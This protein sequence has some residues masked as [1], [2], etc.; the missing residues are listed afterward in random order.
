MPQIFDNNHDYPEQ[1]LLTALQESLQH[2]QTMRADFCVGYFNLRGWGALA[3]YVETWSGADDNCCRVLIGMQA[4]PEAEFRDA[5]RQLKQQKRI[6]LETAKKLE[7]QLALEFREQLTVGLPTAHDERVL[8]QL[9]QQL[10]TRKL[11]VKLYTRQRLHAKL[12][13]C[14]QTDKRV[15]IVGYLG[16]S[17]LTLSGLSAQGELNIDVVEKDATTKL[18]E[19]FE[20]RWADRFSMDISEELIRV[21]EDSWA[22]EKLVSPY[23]IYIKM[24]Y[25]LSRE[26][27]S[28]LSEFAIP[29]VFGDRLF[30]YQTAAVKVAAHHLNKRGGVLIGDVVGL[31]K[32]LM[33]AALIKI[34]EEDYGY[35]TLII[36]PKNLESMWCEEYVERYGLRAK[37]LSITMVKREL[38]DLRRFRMVVLD[39]SHNLRNRD[40][41]IYRTIRDYIEKNECKCILLSATPYNKTYL[42]L[43]NQLRLFI[44]DNKSLSIRP[45]RFIREIGE[46]DFRSKYQADPRSLAAFEH[47]PHPE[48]W[49]DLMRLFMVRRT[50]SFIQQYYASLDEARQRYYLTFEDG[51]H[52]YFPQRL[53]KTVKFDIHRQYAQLYDDDV[54]STING[55]HLPRYG[56]G[57]YVQAKLAETGNEA[58]KGILKDL[59]K[60]GKRLM[61][62]C[63][64]NLFKRLES[65]GQIFLQSLERHIL[66]NYVYLYALQH[67]LELPIGTQDISW[68][69]SRQVDADSD[70]LMSE[71]LFNSENDSEDNEDVTEERD[72]WRLDQLQ[73]QAQRL[74]EQYQQK[75]RRR[76]KWVSSRFF[77]TSLAK[78][79]QDDAN[80][81]L[82]LL[83]QCGAWNPVLDDKLNAL[84]HL[85]TITHPDEKIIIF[86]Q[87]A[88]TVR[89]LEQQLQARGMKA[90]A[91]VTG[92]SDNPTLLAQR[93]SP[94]S[95]KKEIAS[96]DELRVLIATDVLSE[97]QNLQDAHIVVNFDIAWAIIR[98]IQRAGRVDRIGQKA[99]TIYCYTFLPAEGVERVIRLR[100]RVRQ[101]LSEN[102]EVV[103]TDEAFFEDDRNEQSVLDLYNERAGILDAEDDVDVDL[104]SYAYQ[105]WQSAIERDNA[106]ENRIKSLPDVTHASKA[107]IP[108]LNGQAG[109]LVYLRASDG[110]DALAWM[111]E[112]GNSVSESQF[113]ILNAAKCD[114]S[115][116]ALE[117][118]ETHYELVAQGVEFLLQ[119][120]GQHIGGQLG[121]PTSP[122]YR[123]Y[124][125]LEAFAKKQRGTLWERSYE[126]RGLYR[127]LETLY[128]YPLQESA[129]AAVA[130][131]LKAR[132]TDEQL[133]ELVIHLHADQRLC[134]IEGE[135]Q[136]QDPRIICSL[137]LRAT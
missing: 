88:D 36:C 54:I 49:R 58:E 128:R 27:Q 50:R 98:L 105:I 62:F 96:A 42:D 10:R 112:Q 30:D 12:Y 5:M 127:A 81:L 108:Y 126:E 25:H 135:T 4:P 95:N 43:S 70:A 61:G 74:Y 29:S 131:N 45:E 38:P 18:A 23:E 24:A 65:S 76:F 72:L 83:Q 37:V 85:L 103:G 56:L 107:H 67:G 89:Y 114:P 26:A 92:D 51:T 101:R 79:L 57:N 64:T 134:H 68:L 130:R 75:Y 110:N 35:D 6:D 32:S 46:A 90:L 132:A 119:N 117:R 1:I 99:D 115:E 136:D 39:E 71:V 17:N 100:S 118:A 123:L 21:I 77:H 69:D 87:F 121:K 137:G 111:D 3:P 52:S 102:A 40:G 34:F 94:N 120:E 59:S 91:G 122:R 11:R 86:T 14:H 15:P 9:A 60:A 97:G 16:S 31:G 113:T 104:S 7:R 13:L 41:K 33:A 28:G 2:P 82:Q 53:P 19:W 125:R 55:L 80:K 84:H 124:N 78:H 73:A 133:A 48:D 8:R 106:L 116:P 63:R 66:R 44:A 109:V 20:E 93:F 47:S 129:V 22:R